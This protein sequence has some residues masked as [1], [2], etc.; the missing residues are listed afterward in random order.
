MARSQ[1]DKRPNPKASQSASKLKRRPAQSQGARNPVQ[2]Q[3]TIRPTQNRGDEKRRQDSRVRQQAAVRPNA[4]PRQEARRNSSQVKKKRKKR[5][6]MIYYI[7][8]AII[9]ITTS[10]SL[11]LTVF[12]DVK[13]IEVKD[14]GIYAPEQVKA[15]SG[16]N[17]GDNLIRLNLGFSEEKIMKHFIYYDDVDISR[18]FPDGVEIKCE[19]ATTKFS[20][21]DENDTY[22]Y[23]SGKGRVL[24]VGQAQQAENTTLISGFETKNLKQGDTIDLKE[25]NAKEIE[26]IYN[27]AKKSGIGNITGIEFKAGGVNILYEN[28][29]TIQVEDLSRLEYELKGASEIIQ[30]YV[31]TQEQGTIIYQESDKR[32]HFMP[33]R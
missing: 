27:V 1:A 23:I 3:M 11:C 30:K 32:F 19:V 13:N 16:I 22:L 2:S 20:C 7:M 29:I 5:R 12:F 4:N 28:R 18:K 24:E 26:N 17:I 31:G 33:K 21:K 8:I 15:V 9:V 6:Y 14:P 10:I 25:T